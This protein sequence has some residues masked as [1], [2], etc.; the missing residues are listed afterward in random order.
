MVKTPDSTALEELSSGISEDDTAG[1][2]SILSQR[3]C[4]Q[5]WRAFVA[6]RRL[7]GPLSR[8]FAH[9]VIVEALFHFQL[10]LPHA[11]AIHEHHH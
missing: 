1:Q 10:V 7:G 8:T 6:T 3:H 9:I 4:G 5:E 11:L 2:R